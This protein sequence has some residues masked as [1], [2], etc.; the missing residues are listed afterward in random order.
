M[1]VTEVS[2]MPSY[3]ALLEKQHDET[4][5][6]LADMLIGLTNFFRDREAFE[7]LERD[8][9]PQIVQHAA[10]EQSEVRIWAP[11]CSTGEEAY[12]LAVI[13]AGEI[14][15]QHAASKIQIFATDVD[16][17]AIAVARK[18]LYPETIVTDV[19]PTY[20]RQYFTKEGSRYGIAKIIRDSILF[21]PHNVLRDPPFSRL[22]LITCRNLLIYLDRHAQ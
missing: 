21:A 18:G 6:L 7:A 20:L 8:V 19:P 14:Q 12:S 1:Q 17:R 15:R 4:A 2:D 22:Q 5:A 3:V 13:F 11:A 9:V 10:A 16:D